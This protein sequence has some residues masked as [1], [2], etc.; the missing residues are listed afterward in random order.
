M[1]IKNIRPNMECTLADGSEVKVLSV[2]ADE[3]NVKVE[4]L[5]SL[6]NPEIPVGDVR[7]I[8]Y[9]EIIGEIAGTHTEGL[10]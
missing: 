4:Y 7:E 6:D 5:D 10:T 9:E 3:I 2:M 1:N 8:P